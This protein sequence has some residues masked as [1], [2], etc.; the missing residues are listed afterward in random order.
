[1]LTK[2]D[3]KISYA[4]EEV[5]KMKIQLYEQMQALPLEQALKELL[6]HAQLTMNQLVTTGRLVRM[7]NDPLAPELEGRA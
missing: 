7:P 5:W 3:I 2:N 6:R 4:Q 1:M